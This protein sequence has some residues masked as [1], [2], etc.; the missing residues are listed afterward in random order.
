MN[1]QTRPK[2]EKKMEKPKTIVLGLILM[3]GVCALVLA[4]ANPET[5]AGGAKIT[6]VYWG[7]TA[8]DAAIR[9]A[10][11][12]FQAANPEISVEPMY[13]PGDLD[14]STYNAK[15]KA[16]AASDTLPDVGYFRPEEFANYASKDFFLDLTSLVERDDMKKSYLPQTWLSVG[17]KLF[18]AYTA[19]ECQV[20]WYNRSMLQEAGIAQPP[21]K[22]DKGW[23]WEQF[24]ANLKKLTVDNSGRHGGEAGFNAN[25]VQRYGVVYDLWSAMYYPTL[26]SNGGGVISDDGKRIILDSPESVDAF[27]KLADLINRDHVMPYMGGGS[28]LP[29]PSVMLTNKQLGFWVTGQW[30]LLELG[31]IEELPL[32]VAAL[33]IQKKPAQLYVSG[34]NVVFKSSKYPEEAW[35]LQKWMMNPT[36]TLDLYTSGLWMPTKES[37][38]SDPADLARWLDNDVHPQGFKEAVLDSMKVAIPEPI[39]IKN[40]NQIWGDYL[41]AAMESIWIGQA[42]AKKALTEAAERVRASGLLQGTY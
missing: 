8:E 36:K 39:M 13:L 2:G 42:T 7:S 20:M 3:L 33:P 40:I 11:K 10:L 16:M 5:Q 17:G 26:W 14:G 31:G 27:Q 34:V 32:G 23:S 21:V 9:S 28:G 18:G 29:S 12:D 19:A 15:M 35:E 25:N 1:N 6:Y 30:T 4:G 38:Y 37:F 22:Y 24:T 41:N